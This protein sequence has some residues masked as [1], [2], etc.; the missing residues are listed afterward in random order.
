MHN[1]D[2]QD[3][4]D[5]FYEMLYRFAWSL[6]RNDAD[7]CDL[8]QQTFA[9]WARKGHQLRDSGKVRSWLF[10]TLYREFVAT[11]RHQ[12]QFPHQELDAQHEEITSV[13]SRTVEEMDGRTVLR[14]L[15]QVEVV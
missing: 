13:E 7:A 8:T 3:L 14:T 10:T 11:W 15:Y 9:L 4:V 6:T 1:L 5:Q 2:F 12:T